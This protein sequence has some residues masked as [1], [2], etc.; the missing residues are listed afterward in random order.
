MATSNGAPTLAFGGIL[1]DPESDDECDDE[2]ARGRSCLKLDCRRSR[3]IGG[4]AARDGLVGARSSVRGTCSFD[5]DA[6]LD[7]AVGG[8]SRL[9]GKMV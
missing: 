6:M 2:C 9:G 3:F 1:S 5:T 8:R 7:A 4:T